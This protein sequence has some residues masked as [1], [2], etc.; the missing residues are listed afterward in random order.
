MRS[1]FIFFIGIC[2]AISC[3]NNDTTE[4]SAT[5][6]SAQIVVD[7]S[8]APIIEDQ[9]LVFESSYPQV[10]LELIYK[11]EVRVLNTLLQ[12]SVKVAR[13]TR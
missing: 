3:R 6:G 8:F 7:E 5:V 13:T 10:K 1:K 12:D 11:P 9:Y 2:A 4:Q